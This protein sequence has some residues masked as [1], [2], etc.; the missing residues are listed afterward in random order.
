MIIELFFGVSMKIKFSLIFTIILFFQLSA[1]AEVK[2]VSTATEIYNNTNAESAS[3]GFSRVVFNVPSTV[4]LGRSGVK[5]LFGC[6]YR[7]PFELESNTF[8]IQNPIFINAFTDLLKEANYNVAGDPNALFTDN[9]N[10]P[11]FLVAAMITEF[12]I[13]YCLYLEPGFGTAE[14]ISSD[15]DG[16]LHMKLDWQVY[17]IAKEEVVFRKETEGYHRIKRKT[18]NILYALLEETYRSA[19]R[20]FLET[21]ELATVLAS[22]VPIEDPTFD[23][24][25]LNYVTA[26]QNSDKISLAQA[27][28]SV[29][30]I[31]AGGHGSGFIIS[32]DGY[33]LTNQHVVGELDTVIVSFKNGMEVEGQVLRR[34]KFRDVA[35]VKI[36]L[37]R[38]KPLLLQTNE[39]EVGVNVYTIGSPLDASLSSTVSQGIISA[40]R[41]LDDQEFI[42]SDAQTNPGNSGGPMVDENGN[43]IAISV[44]GRTDGEGVNFFIPIEFALE[45][46]NI[47]LPDAEPS[48]Y[49]SND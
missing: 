15:G 32:S 37:N 46:L 30:T 6:G 39:P 18:D 13:D 49:S 42:Q 23:S 1:F 26:A 28:E 5:S 9:N 21:D 20:N 14:V 41:M 4:T 43:V 7:V 10:N 36:P 2:V 47:S 16:Q 48:K 38:L 11:E 12:E 40:F 17:S 8:N 34:A 35:L 19:L 3:V 29:V 25:N 45:S 27:T 44:S 31:K 24:I 33:I 22:N